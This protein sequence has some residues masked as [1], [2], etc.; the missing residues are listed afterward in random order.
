MVHDALPPHYHYVIAFTVATALL[1]AGIALFRHTR[2]V[3]RLL[4]VGGDLGGAIVP[5]ILALLAFVAGALLLFSGSVPAVGHRLLWVYDALPLPLVDLSHFFDNLLGAALL[6]LAHGIERR[7]DAAFHLTIGALLAAIVFSLARAL[8]YEQ[9]FVLAIVLVLFLPSK[10]YFSRKTSLIEERFSAS[11]IVAISLVVTASIA[12]GV[13]SF[14]KLQLRADLLYTAQSQE[15]RFLRS[16]AGLLGVLIVFALFRLVRP[17]RLTAPKVTLADLASVKTLVDKSHDASTQ[18]ALLGDK[19]ILFNESRTGFIMYGLSGRSLVSLGDP[20]A[21]VED[22]PSLI[23]SFILRARDQGLYPV[24]YKASPVMLYLYLDFGLAVVKLGEE[25]SVSLDDFTLEG[26]NRKNLRR[27][28]R[29]MVDMGCTFEML[30]PAQI[31]AVLPELRSVSD[32][33]LATRQTKEKGFSLGFFQDDYILQ[34][35]IGV[36]RLG[37]KIVAFANLWRS[38]ENEELE[39]DLMRYPSDAPPGIMRYVIVEMMLWGKANG[40][41]SFNLGMAPLSGML[42]SAAAP[43]WHQLATAV[44]GYGERFYN[45]KGIHDFKEWFHPEWEPRFL[46]SPGAT[47]RPVILANIAKLISGGPDKVL[48]AD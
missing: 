28:W 20:V 1:Y 9:A 18:L 14:Q 26:A 13:I 11:W 27:V 29:K 44:R 25:A 19:H 46:V 40:Y 31:K 2:G 8:D 33:W 6:I 34:H 39:V 12:L 3:Q 5:R 43:V 7:L 15:A 47:A 35:P 36:A 23:E 37:E 32:S 41:R 48:P 16:T 24:F 17:V 42:Q 21:P 22:V 4:L 10:K 38:G 30:G 45:F